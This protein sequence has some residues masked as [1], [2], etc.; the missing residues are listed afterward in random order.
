MNTTE[1]TNREKAI[2]SIVE[3]YQ[4][5]SRKEVEQL[6][7]ATNGIGGCSIAV[8]KS[9]SSD[10]SNNTEVADQKINIGASY[11]KMLS[12]DDN[13][14]AK[15][16]VNSVDVNTYNYE[17]LDISGYTLEG[18]KQAV[19]EALPIALNELQAPKK[20]KDTTADIWLNKALVFNLNTLRLSV[21]GQQ[22]NKSVSVQGEVKITKSKPLTIAKKLI[23]KSAK[24]R[25][26]TIRR[27]A[28]D[29]IL[30]K[31]IVN[32]ETVTLS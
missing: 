8:I 12:K 6:I 15:F 14:Y 32:K 24:G 27:F 30:T 25:T 7:L 1:I 2:L 29:N 23:E 9:Y 4:G 22:I 19:L 3:N 31:I 5:I 18:F 11:E 26:A 28:L 17:L 20:P 16:D 10:A 21:F 13:I